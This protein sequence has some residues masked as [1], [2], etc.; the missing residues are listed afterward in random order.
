MKMFSTITSPVFS[1]LII[2]IGANDAAYLPTEV[3]LFRTLRAMNEVRPFKLVFLLVD[4]D[5]FQGE[6]R[7]MVA[8]ALNS[9][10]ARGLLD[11]LDS[12]PAIRNA[13]IREQGWDKSVD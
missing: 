2:L 4:I 9:V 1:E 11:F 12:P 5:L 8:G 13:Q 3:P 10:T 7:R 6:A